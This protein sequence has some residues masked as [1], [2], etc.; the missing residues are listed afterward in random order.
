MNTAEKHLDISAA[1]CLVEASDV[2][3][4][5]QMWEANPAVVEMAVVESM[6]A[7]NWVDP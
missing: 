4:D 3:C 1:L 6:V 5:H 7:A 2:P